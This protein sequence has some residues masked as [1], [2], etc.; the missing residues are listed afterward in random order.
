MSTATTI[1]TATGRKVRIVVG[2][3]GANFGFSSTIKAL[4]GKVIGYGGVAITEQAAF[5]Q[6]A[7]KA[8]TL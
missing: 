2:P 8:E 3:E 7:V 6:A 4:N 5:E 1:T